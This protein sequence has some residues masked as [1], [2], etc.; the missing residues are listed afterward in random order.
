MAG[1]YDS[2][3]WLQVDMLEPYKYQGIQIQ[4]REDVEMW[5]ETFSLL[6]SADGVSFTEY[7][8]ENNNTV[9][10]ITRICIKNS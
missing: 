3:Q 2:L 10:K 5:V 8:D 4:G 9:S 1:T 6:H 7:S